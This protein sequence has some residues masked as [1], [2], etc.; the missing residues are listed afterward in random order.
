MSPKHDHTLGLFPGIATGSAAPLGIQAGG[1]NTGW[2]H[3]QDRGGG[4][5]GLLGTSKKGLGG[6]T[7]ET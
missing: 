7:Q 1:T 6:S 5:Q 2:V 4:W 3:W